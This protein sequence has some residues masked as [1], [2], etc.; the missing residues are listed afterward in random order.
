MYT[1]IAMFNVLRN[2]S[3]SDVWPVKNG[4]S[5]WYPR[6][7][8]MLAM[9]QTWKPGWNSK[10]MPGIHN[11]SLVL[12]KIHTAVID[13]SHRNKRCLLLPQLP[14]EIQYHILKCVHDKTEQAFNRLIRT[15]AKVHPATCHEGSD[16]EMMRISAL[17]TSALD[18]GRW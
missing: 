16:M 5:C 8:R 3:L 9:S 15:K 2:E 12:I 13:I 11:L 1:F 4:T 7:E 6:P 18:G 10:K 14:L 17:F